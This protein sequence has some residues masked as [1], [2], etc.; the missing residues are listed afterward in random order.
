MDY[1]VTYRCSRNS[2]LNAWKLNL[3][4]CD[5]MYTGVKRICVNSNNS[6]WDK[7]PTKTNSNFPECT[8]YTSKMAAQGS[9][10]LHLGHWLT[11]DSCIFT[12]VHV[13]CSRWWTKQQNR[14]IPIH[15]CKNNHPSPCYTSI[16]DA[17][18]QKRF[19]CF[20]P[21]QCKCTY[22]LFLLLWFG[23]HQPPDT[24]SLAALCSTVFTAHQLEATSRFHQSCF[25]CCC[26]IDVWMKAL[27]H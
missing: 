19:I 22:S 9:L 7:K 20:Q 4:S 1:C 13:R 24:S 8:W 5:V 18:E 27:K 23:L 12:Y 21:D 6:Y 10:T 15:H 2:T 17:E 3:G 14:V 26:Y 16:R 25:C 11:W